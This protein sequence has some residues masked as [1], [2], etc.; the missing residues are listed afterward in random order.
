MQDAVNG[1]KHA[2]KTER[3]MRRHWLL[4]QG[5]VLFILIFR[6][7]LLWVCMTFVMSGMMFALELLNTAIERGVDLTTEGQYALLAKQAKDCAAGAVLIAA[8]A[9]AFVAV[10]FILSVYPF[11]VYLMTMFHVGS[12]LLVLMADVVLSLAVWQGHKFHAIKNHWTT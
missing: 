1:V 8:C 12:A 4:F 2:F 10:G 5:L 6:P 9:S 11:H 3:N 7:S